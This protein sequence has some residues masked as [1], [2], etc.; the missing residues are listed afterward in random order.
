MNIVSTD[1]GVNVGMY[2]LVDDDADLSILY[3]AIKKKMHYL[4]TTIYLILNLC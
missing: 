1:L 4:I 3:A 2:E